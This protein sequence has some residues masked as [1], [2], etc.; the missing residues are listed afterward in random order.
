MRCLVFAVAILHILSLYGCA[1]FDG[2]AFPREYSQGMGGAY[3]PAVNAPQDDPEPG[4]SSDYNCKYGS[5][6]VK[7]Q[8]QTLGLCAQNVTPYGVPTFAPP[9]PESALVGGQGD[10]QWNTDCPVGFRCIKGNAISGHCL[11]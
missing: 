1:S 10:C 7:Q 11:R 9:N 8:Y 2:G 3:P 4:C 6:C 5:R